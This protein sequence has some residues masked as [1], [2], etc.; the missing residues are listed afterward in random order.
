MIKPDKVIFLLSIYCLLCIPV[1]SQSTLKENGGK[2]EN[3]ESYVHELLNKIEEQGTTIDLL[4]A[5]DFNKLPL[6][7]VNHK[8]GSRQVLAI[9]T[10]YA[11]N[12]NWFFNIYASIYIPGTTKPLIFAGIGIGFGPGGISSSN[13]AR[14]ALI[15]EHRVDIS[16]DIALVLPGDGSS[17][18]SFDCNGFHSLHLKG[19][20]EFSPRKIIP[21][22]ILARGQTKVTASLETDITDLNNILIST[23]ITPF[24]VRGLEGFSFEVKNATL[25]MSDIDNP[26]GFSFPL[27]YQEIY[28]ESLPLWRGFY[29][30]EMNVYLPGEFRDTQNTSPTT[31]GRVQIQARDFLLDELGVSGKFSVSNLLS[32]D[33]GDI[34]NWGL[35]IDLIAIELIQNR[36]KGGGLRGSLRVPFLGEKPLGYEAFVYQEA[37]QV[38][39]R[40]L[41]QTNKHKNYNF[42]GGEIQLAEGC[43]V[44][45]EKRAGKL[46]P[47]ARL[48]GI[49]SLNKSFLNINQINFQDLV[50]T[51]EKPYVHSG[52]F[53]YVGKENSKMAGYKLRIKEI[54]AGIFSGRF[55]FGIRAVINLMNKEDKGFSG[56]TFVRVQAKI[57]ETQQRIGESTINKTRWSFDKIKVDEVIIKARTTALSLDGKVTFFED[58]P[59]LWQRI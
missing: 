41:V 47:Q 8:A 40:F 21:D 34:G 6:G 9:D 4:L 59:H 44:G 56:E 3:L 43:Q 29:L 27:E 13:V 57:E 39:F 45:F 23:S 28:Q 54:R 51:G 50:I 38:N 33:R 32:L 37:E 53:S 7:I 25:D 36:L 2:E 58:R 42:F 14:M 52:I 11:I 22:P 17:Y 20:F 31:T 12:G 16:Q 46:I 35:S 18:L 10:A 30:Q 49:I 15:S 19:Q 1:Y 48:H 5:E 26:P 55:E 24:Q